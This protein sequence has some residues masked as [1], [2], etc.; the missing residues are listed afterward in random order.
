MKPMEFEAELWLWD[1]RRADTWIF[2][3]VPP[4]QSEEIRDHAAARPPAGFGSVRVQVTI[5][6]STWQ[7]SVFPGGDGRYDLPVKKSVRRAEG[8]EAGDRVQVRLEVLADG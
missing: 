3:S 2:L 7:T 1:A 8:V 6:A 4:A 5:G